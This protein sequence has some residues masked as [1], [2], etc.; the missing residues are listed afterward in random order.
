M[1]QLKIPKWTAILL[2]GIA[3]LA[4][5]DRGDTSID[6]KV[7]GDKIKFEIGFAGSDN[8]LQT[9]A[10]TDNLF[11]STWENGDEIGIFA[12]RHA[13]GHTGTLSASGNYIHNGKLTYNNGEW[14]PETQLYYP[15]GGYEL[16]FYAYYP[17]DATAINP[18]DI[19]FK[20]KTDQYTTAGFDK[21]DFMMA[22]PSLNVTS[23]QPVDIR[24]GHSL[25]LLQVEI[26]NN[27]GV[28][29]NND[30]RV[31]LKN[32]VTQ[33]NVNLQTQTVTA[34]GA[35][36]E[37]TLFPLTATTYRAVVPAGNITLGVV[38]F[39]Q[40]SPNWIFNRYQSAITLTAGKATRLQIT[41]NN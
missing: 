39:T 10:T 8:G 18:L 26:T 25:A 29:M 31:I 1:R 13:N 4:S 16:D 37:I 38:D 14:M 36:A 17:Y 40:P 22:A 20:V 6:L 7:I 23:G 33:A 15:G 21:S 5:C 41:L 3:I 30:F 12:I 2:A 24:F 32:A 28:V 9:R 35:A 11:N 27:T 19:A 34:S